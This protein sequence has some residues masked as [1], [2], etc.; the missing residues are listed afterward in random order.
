[1]WYFDNSPF[2]DLHPVTEVIFPPLWLQITPSGGTG[3]AGD[4]ALLKFIGTY[5]GHVIEFKVHTRLFS[6]RVLIFR[7]YNYVIT[8]CRLQCHVPITLFLFFIF[9]ILLDLAVL[10]HSA[11][12][13]CCTLLYYYSL[14][15]LSRFFFYEKM[16]HPLS[17]PKLKCNAFPVEILLTKWL[18][19]DGNLGVELFHWTF[20]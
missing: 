14:T 13:I 15:L 18:R 3:G 1:M 7:M 11:L 6:L 5:A 4:S 9:A 16:S 2:D 10:W 19:A 8:V 20:I 17:W 12:L